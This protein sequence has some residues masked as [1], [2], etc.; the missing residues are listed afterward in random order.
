MTFDEWERSF[1][2]ASNMT[3]REYA[4]AAWKAA[5]MVERETCAKVCEEVQEI[6]GNDDSAVACV[7]AI[8]ARTIY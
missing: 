8:R 5:A 6:F 1:H 3:K 7:A 2:N 4:R